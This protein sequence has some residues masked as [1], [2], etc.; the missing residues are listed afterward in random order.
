[1]EMQVCNVQN[2]SSVCNV[3]YQKFKKHTKANIVRLIKV[4]LFF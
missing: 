1:M 4:S 2:Y 3:K